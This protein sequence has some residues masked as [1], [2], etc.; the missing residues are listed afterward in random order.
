MINPLHFSSGPELGV[1]RDLPRGVQ[2]LRYSKPRRA[3]GSNNRQWYFCD[4]CGGWILGAPFI[5]TE[6]DSESF[7]E[8]RVGRVT[9]CR[10]CGEELSFTGVYHKE[11]VR[12]EPIKTDVNQIKKEPPRIQR[13]SGGIGA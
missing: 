5:Q 11:A 9:R 2:E 1:L 4:A 12:V 8:G 6:S 3:A 7:M 10:R 13:G